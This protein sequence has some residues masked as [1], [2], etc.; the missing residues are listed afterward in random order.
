MKRREFITLLGGAATAWPLMARAQQQDGRARA[1]LLRI[2]QLRADTTADK[3]AQFLNEIVSQVGWTTQLPWPNGPMEQR[4][5]DAPRLLRQ[6]PPITDLQFLDDSGVEQLK[7]ARL[8]TDVVASGADLSKDPK[9]TEARAHKIYFGPVY[10]RRESEPFMTVSL[11]GTRREAGV[12]I[13]EVGLKLVWDL[14]SQTMIGKSGRVYVVDGEDRLIA[15]PDIGLVLR[16]TDM[17]KLAQVQAA[18]AAGDGPTEVRAAH[19]IN[20]RQVLSASAGIAGPGWHVFVELP[21]AE[22][23]TAV[24]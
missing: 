4:R 24:P 16:K 22:A 12:T 5:F 7:V 13:A 3:I 9:F 19:D 15:H 1:L 10:F 18:R 21:L 20:G 6:V 2:L 23:E 17:S 11:A 8:R 14:A